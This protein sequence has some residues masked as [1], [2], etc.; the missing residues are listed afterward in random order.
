MPRRPMAGRAAPALRADD[1]SNNAEPNTEVGLAETCAP[2][3][4]RLVETTNR[5]MN[6]YFVF[7]AEFAA[8]DVAFAAA[9][10]FF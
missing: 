10:A 6:G 1:G 5:G 2:R 3:N 7:L 4:G 9:A 8:E